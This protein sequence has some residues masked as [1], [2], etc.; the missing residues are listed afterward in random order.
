[1]NC[2]RREK[3]SDG[4]RTVMWGKINI[5]KKTRKG[6]NKKIKRYPLPPQLHGDLKTDVNL[7]LI[8]FSIFPHTLFLLI[9]NSSK[10][11]SKQSPHFTLAP[12]V[13]VRT[14]LSSRICLFNQNA[15]THCT[16]PSVNVYLISTLLY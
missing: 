16:G 12:L 4:E 10:D 8:L 5:M 1:M 13:P 2:R 11:L 7:I 14:L 9:S 6:R 15:F 3:R